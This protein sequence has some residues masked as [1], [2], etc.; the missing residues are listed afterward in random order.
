MLS[1]VA[2]SLYWMNRYIER[3]EDYARFVDVNLNLMLEMPPGLS[4]QWNPLVMAT[5]DNLV[6]CPFEDKLNFGGCTGLRGERMVEIFDFYNIRF[7]SLL[8]LFFLKHLLS[9]LFSNISFSSIQ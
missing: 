3:A 6:L 2:D 5:G 1:R 4:E 8:F 7:S 9:L